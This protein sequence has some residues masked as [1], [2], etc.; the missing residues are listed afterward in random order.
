MLAADLQEA[1]TELAVMQ[2]ASKDV[3]RSA[4]LVEALIPCVPLH[5]NNALLHDALPVKEQGVDDFASTPGCRPG[6]SQQEFRV[7]TPLNRE[8]FHNHEQVEGSLE[9]GDLVT[10]AHVLQRSAWSR[11]CNTRTR[12]SGVDDF[13]W[14]WCWRG[15][16]C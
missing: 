5:I 2:N 6:R 4:A 1:V 3:I 15:C 16:C 8:S 10:R 11:L 12:G 7:V 13:S 14:Y 9:R